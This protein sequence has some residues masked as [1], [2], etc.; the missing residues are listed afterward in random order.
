MINVN[1]SA[2]TL[3]AT[4]PEKETPLQAGA[5]RGLRDRYLGARWWHGFLCDEKLECLLS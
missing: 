3:R 1:G 4:E 2:Q 5:V